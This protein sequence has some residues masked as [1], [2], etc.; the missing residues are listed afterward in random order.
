MLRSEG[1]QGGRVRRSLC[2]EALARGGPRLPSL[3]L[4]PSRP[5]TL[6]STCQRGSAF[7]RPKRV[8]GIR[9][10]KG[11][12]RIGGGGRGT[13]RSPQRAGIRVKDWLPPQV[14]QGEVVRRRG[15]TAAAIP[16]PSWAKG[17]A[18][19]ARVGGSV[20]GQLGRGEAAEGA[21]ARQGSH[22]RGEMSHVANG[23]REEILKRSEPRQLDTCE[24][25]R[26]VPRK[27]LAGSAAL[28]RRRET[29][30]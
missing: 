10:G 22:A 1:S 3:A 9:Q 5:P 29:D 26:A 12:G 16:R 8:C 28:E 23:V 21:Q 15:K 25:R 14:Q 24:G 7:H 4:Q 27:A 2:D 30:S 19:I 20:R 11:K 6:R 18:W 17:D 13:R